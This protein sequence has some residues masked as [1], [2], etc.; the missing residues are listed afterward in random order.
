MRIACLISVA[1]VVAGCSGYQP[2]LPDGGRARVNCATS[3]IKVPVTILDRAGDPAPGAIL[4]VE[5]TGTLEGENVIADDRGVALVQDKWGPAYLK[6]IA[7]LND[8]RS[9]PAYITYI[10]TDCSSGVTPRSLT[11]QVQ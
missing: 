1:V 3:D 9:P 6:V 8:L 5:D 2:Y 4:E 7:N 10:G 11:L